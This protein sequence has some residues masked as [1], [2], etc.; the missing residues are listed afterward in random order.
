M[1]NIMRAVEQQKIPAD[2]AKSFVF[3]LFEEVSSRRP[4]MTMEA[5]K[6]ALDRDEDELVALIGTWLIGWDIATPGSGRRE[7]RIL[8][9]SV[10]LG[11]SFLGRNERPPL[12]VW[13]DVLGLIF[14]P[15]ITH[16]PCMTGVEV[17]HSLNC[18][19]THVMR[20]IESE[21]LK[22]L[23]GTA[24]GKGRGRSPFVTCE[25]FAQFLR[26][27][28]EDSRNIVALPNESGGALLLKK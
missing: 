9:R 25:S 2:L 24:Y 14:L 16:R 15:L 26:A 18:S 5:A 27:R 20:L 11:A 4:T 12:W 1:A 7:W 22:L 23:P 13:G 3:P 6:G 10:S 17:Q 19:S 28:L 21:A 8:T